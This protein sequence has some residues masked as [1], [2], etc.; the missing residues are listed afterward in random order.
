MERVVVE[1]LDQIE[2]VYSQQVTHQEWPLHPD[3]HLY[4]R[5]CRERWEVPIMDATY[6]YHLKAMKKTM[7]WYFAVATF[8][9]KFA[10]THTHSIY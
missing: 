10:H 9:I 6:H 7:L 4:I 1:R 3:I 5:Q 8:L 2:K